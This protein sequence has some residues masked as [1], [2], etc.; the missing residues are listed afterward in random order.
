VINTK[1]KIIY[2]GITKTGSESIYSSLWEKGLVE[3]NTIKKYS[4]AR[5]RQG[6]IS[7]KHQTIREVQQHFPHLD[8]DKYF[9]FTFVRNPYERHISLYNWSRS[10]GAIS[11]TLSF[12]NFTKKV[13]NREYK[14]YPYRYIRQVDWLRKKNGDLC[15]DFVGKFENISDDFKKVCNLIGHQIP[16]K[17]TNISTQHINLSH[18]SHDVSSLIYNFYAED[19][20]IFGYEK[21]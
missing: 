9:K 21:K 11:S 14:K 4:E 18:M 7:T 19:F 17:K 1:E 16:L 15:I 20:D 6:T 5:N 2:I 13:V 3:K 12:L 8:L 10:S